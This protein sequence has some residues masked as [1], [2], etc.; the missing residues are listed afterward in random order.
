MLKSY[1]TEC[2]DCKEM[3]EQFVEDLSE[4]KSCPI[5]GGDTKR[6][7]TSMNYKLIYNN[8]TDCC[9]WGAH[10]YESSQYWSQIRKMREKG[11]DVKSPD[12]KY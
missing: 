1:D 3:I 5:C 10:N 4:L 7:F 12:D 2:V 6:I 11:H 9:G 8:K